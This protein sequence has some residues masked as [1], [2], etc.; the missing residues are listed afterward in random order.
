MFTNRI[1]IDR[2]RW[3]LI[4]VL[5]AAQFAHGALHACARAACCTSCSARCARGR[6]VL[7]A[8]RMSHFRHSTQRAR[9]RGEETARRTLGRNFAVVACYM[10]GEFE[11]ID[12]Y[13][14]QVSL[15]KLQTESESIRRKQ[16]ICNLNACF[17]GGQAVLKYLVIPI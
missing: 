15:R 11:G 7:R 10:T 12:S 9:A 2:R 5:F 3:K 8:R 13:G 6:G 1:Q 16:C 17:T 14:D 4:R